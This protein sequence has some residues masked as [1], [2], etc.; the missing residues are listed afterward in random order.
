MGQRRGSSCIT[1]EWNFVGFHSV[2]DKLSRNI[3]TLMYFFMI[4]YS[5]LFVAGSKLFYWK[6]AKNPCKGMV[7]L[8]TWNIMMTFWKC[9]FKQSPSIGHSVFW[10]ILLTWFVI[11]KYRL[12]QWTMLV[13]HPS[14]TTFWPC[15]IFILHPKTFKNHVLCSQV[16]VSRLSRCSLD[17]DQEWFSK[18]DFSSSNWPSSCGVHII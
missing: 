11:N 6:A 14:S 3:G 9:Q 18:L 7:I 8:V 12:Q 16:F 10:K 2:G 1:T 17:F 5:I 4:I 15:R 13:Q